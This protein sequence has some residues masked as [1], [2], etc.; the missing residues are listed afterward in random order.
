MRVFQIFAA[1][2]GAVVAFLALAWCGLNLFAW[3]RITGP[4]TIGEL[5]ALARRG[6]P[7]AQAVVDY[8]S[9]HGLFPENVKDLVPAYLPKWPKD[10][11]YSNGSLE[12]H[13]GIPHTYLSC[14][15]DENTNQWHLI[16]E[17]AQ[18]RKINVPGPAVKK[19]SLSA[20]TMFANRLAAFEKRIT[21]NPG[22]SQQKYSYRDIISF[23]ALSGSNDFAVAECERA[24][25]SFPDWWFPELALAKLRTNDLQAEQDFKSWVQA[26]PTFIN[27]WYLSRFYR[28]KDNY[29]AAFAALDQGTGSSFTPQSDQV[30]EWKHDLQLA[31]QGKPHKPISDDTDDAFWIPDGFALDAVRF[32]CQNRKYDLA[33]KI[34]QSCGVDN[35]A[36]KA[37]AELGM[38]QFDAAIAEGQK[39]ART[40]MY[41]T[42]Q[43]PQFQEVAHAHHTNFYFF[44]QDDDSAKWVLFTMP[45]EVASENNN[46]DE[47]LH[48]AHQNR[49]DG[50]FEGAID[51]CT[52]AIQM[53]PLNDSAY[54]L[55]GWNAFLKNDFDAAIKDATR[56]IQLNL[57][58]G[59]AYG[60]RG[61]ARFGKGDTKGALDDL[62]AAIALCGE[63]SLEGIEDNGLIEFMNGHYQNALGYWQKAVQREPS[64]QRDLQPW[65]EK[66]S[67]H[68]TK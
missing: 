27:Y 31:V 34:I 68:V 65:M 29:E 24:V 37:C 44:E 49:A 10:W 47:A 26:H 19:S 63:S 51:D 22:N 25:R 14:S 55:R 12:H 32:C 36:L 30:E 38:G 48:S 16:G 6:Q 33:L 66:A 57:N 50:N 7:L 40:N 13:S 15:F 17:Y 62:K 35:L 39:A 20:D 56:A 52:K 9:D 64:M 21:S 58:F 61:W 60:T 5:E 18:M 2:A 1:I 45:G 28:E 4:P 54:N 43:W 8:K 42:F 46:V 41:F 11:G 23:T 67:R 3:G 59:N 53:E